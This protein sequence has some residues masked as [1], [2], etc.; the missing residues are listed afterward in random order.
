M[1]L[2]SSFIILR[3]MPLTRNIQIFN[4]KINYFTLLSTGSDKILPLS[5]CGRIQGNSISPGC[6]PIMRLLH[7]DLAYTWSGACWGWNEKCKCTIYNSFNGITMIFTVRR[8]IQDNRHLH[9]SVSWKLRPMMGQ[10]KVCVY[11]RTLPWAGMGI[12]F[13]YRVPSVKPVK[14][15]SQHTLH[16]YV[17]KSNAEITSSS[18]SLSLGCGRSFRRQ[19][20]VIEK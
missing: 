1:F 7:T 14:V 8:N 15:Q 3:R 10:H 16:K 2:C 4:M 11:C 20:W 9:N 13:I 5:K 6:C 17:H 12:E 19:I 18:L